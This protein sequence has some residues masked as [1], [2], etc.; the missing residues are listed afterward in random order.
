MALLTNRNPNAIAERTT[1]T[2]EFTGITS[3]ASIAKGK[4]NWILDKGATDHMIHSA[5]LLTTKSALS[6]RI[7]H[8]PNRSYCIFL[9]KFI[10]LME[11]QGTSDSVRIK[12]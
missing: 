3:C 4:I 2:N 6:N 11:D 10:N 9:R 7:V 8:L 5:S 1:Q 12:C